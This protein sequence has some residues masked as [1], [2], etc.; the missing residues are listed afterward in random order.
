M[1]SGPPKLTILDSSVSK[2]NSLPLYV[3]I[4]P[5]VEVFSLSR[6]YGV[7]LA[8]GKSLAAVES[9][10]SPN[11]AATPMWSSMRACCPSNIVARTLQVSLAYIAATQQVALVHQQYSCACMDHFLPVLSLLPCQH[12]RKVVRTAWFPVSLGLPKPRLSCVPYSCRNWQHNGWSLLHLLDLLCTSGHL[13]MS[14]GRN[15][16]ATIL[17]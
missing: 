3:Q 13:T 17:V 2:Q 12:S 6:A 16:C 9:S 15:S 10:V 14:L 7:M 5:L 11:R 1:K 8:G 4:P